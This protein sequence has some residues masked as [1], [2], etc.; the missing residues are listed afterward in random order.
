MVAKPYR[1]KI[2]KGRMAGLSS[3]STGWQLVGVT[4]IVFGALIL[5]NLPHRN[6]ITRS[7][8][9]PVI[10]R[11]GLMVKGSGGAVYLFRGYTLHRIINPTPAQQAE[12]QQVDDTFL[13]RYGC[14][15]PVDQNGRGLNPL[16]DV[17]L[18][19]RDCGIGWRNLVVDPCIS[20]SWA[21]GGSNR[22]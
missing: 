8:S 4:V 7:A 11:E 5:L 1:T 19:G 16:D 22:S 20:G 17:E 15:E 14:G 12:A 13:A 9:T 21:K 18:A 3:R 10:V 2:N 6:P